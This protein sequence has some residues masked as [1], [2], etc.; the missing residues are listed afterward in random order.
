MGPPGGR[1]DRGRLGR[2]DVEVGEFWTAARTSLAGA[3]RPLPD[4]PQPLPGERL[5]SD[6]ID[7][8]AAALTAEPA[9]A[10]LVVDDADHLREELVAG[11]HQLA[12]ANSP[13]GATSAWRGRPGRARDQAAAG[14]TPETKSSRDTT[15][16]SGLSVKI[17]STP[18]SQNRSCSSSARS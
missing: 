9:P 13:S 15:P 17:P 6:L 18:A 5:P 16:V 8:L 7:R 3:G 14:S 10:V 11:L 2:D 4:V 1:L 12:K